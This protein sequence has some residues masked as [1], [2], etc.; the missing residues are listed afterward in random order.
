MR[1]LT[2]RPFLSVS[3][4]ALTAGLG[5]PV[6]AQSTEAA[7][8]TF[9][10][11]IRIDSHAAQAVLGN[12]EITEEEIDQRNPSSIRD[13]F[14]GV[15]SVQASGG[16]SMATNVFVN[17]LEESL[18]AVTIDGARQNKSPFH[19]TG[20]VL[21]DPALLRRVEI[22][23]GLAPADAGANATGGVIAYEY[24]DAIDLLQPGQTFGG[25]FTLATGTNGYGVRTGMAVYGL[26]GQL[27]YL[28]NI[29]GQSG[30]HYEDGS[31]TTMLGTEPELRNYMARIGYTMDDGS[32]LRFATSRTEDTG[33]RLAQAGP[34][35]LLFIR[36]DFAGVVG[37]DSVLVT[38]YSGR[39]SYTLTWQGAETEVTDLE[40]QLTYNEQELDGIGI[41]GE[42]T[43]FSG[44]L[45]N[46][47]HLSNG[48]VTAGIDGFRERAH[49]F[50]R[51]TGVYGDSGT[52]RLSSVGLYAQARQD[53]TERLSVSYGGRYD[54]Q[55]FTAAT[56]EEFR[57][58]GASVNASLDYILTDTLT[59]N[60]GAASTWGG[61]E[62]GEAALINFG[63]TWDYT[64]FRASQSRAARIGLRYAQG[65]WEVSG[66]LF[67]TA[68]DDIAAVLPTAGAR[69][70]LTDVVSQGFDG[71]VAYQGARGYA[72]VNLTWADVQA[73]G[74]D[75]AT[76]AYYLGR[77]VGSTAALE[78]GVDVTPE[79]TLGGSAQIAFEN[80]L[81][82][83]TLPS[84][85][86]LNLFATWRPAR[87]D[88]LQ[89]RFDVDNVFD[90]T[91]AS[92]SSDGIGL[93]NVVALNEA[94]RTFRVSAV[95]EF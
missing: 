16:A 51:G 38:P 2:K 60:A 13:V 19:H 85:E 7:A 95:V 77:P 92:R 58:S 66:A 40:A 70:T 65:P 45:E 52:E 88:G 3:I 32:R 17:G 33:E 14:A 47:F 78:L 26:V 49:G 30:D 73:N 15:S 94:G 71:S 63:T 24:A 87:Y 34:G 10:G 64:G 56:G 28:L 21:L 55:H 72:R 5:L 12:D 69:G 91:Y 25:R 23:A 67:Y 83:V 80:E 46:V 53:L 4:L 11:T 6:A 36:P 27:D 61:F 9:L 68:V 59:L 22:S 84:Y 82:T 31:G 62:L 76:T 50:G 93:S 43:S 18:L 75:I 54:W 86:V 8:S 48:T 39:T 74:S 37:R 81:E 57:D 79:W 41:W 44:Y 42:N 29:S 20:N 89:V 35:G 1:H 90:T